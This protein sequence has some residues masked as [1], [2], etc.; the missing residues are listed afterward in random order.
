MLAALVYSCYVM[1]KPTTSSL[2]CGVTET[3][4]GYQA[5][6]YLPNGVLLPDPFKV[7]TRWLSE[8]DNSMKHCRLFREQNTDTDKLLSDY[9]A[10]KAYDYFKTKWLKEIHYNSMNQLSIINP[11]IDAYCLLRAKCTSSQWINDPT[12]DVWVYAHKETGQ[13]SKNYCNCA[14]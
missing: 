9:K 7:A 14:A 13:I 1:K 6:L 12:H 5:I 8:T 11:R 2:T 3:F 4:E 10:G